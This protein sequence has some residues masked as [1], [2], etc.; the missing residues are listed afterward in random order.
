MIYFQRFGW[1]LAKISCQLFASGT[2]RV[3]AGNFFGPTDPPITILVGA[4][5][6]PQALDGCG[7]RPKAVPTNFLLL[8]K[9]PRTKVGYTD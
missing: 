5:K 7:G 1:H 4:T 2:L 6:K 8:R 3:D 9:N